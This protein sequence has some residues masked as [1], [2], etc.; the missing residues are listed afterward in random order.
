VFQARYLIEIL[1]S[2]RLVLHVPCG[3]QKS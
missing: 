1:T 2:D 3:S